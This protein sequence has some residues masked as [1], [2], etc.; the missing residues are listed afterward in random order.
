[1]EIFQKQWGWSY[2]TS[3]RLFIGTHKFFYKSIFSIV[4]FSNPMRWIQETYPGKTKNCSENKR[5]FKTQKNGY[6]IYQSGVKR[7]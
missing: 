3:D 1:M 7:H 4:I 2:W 6:F 5:Y